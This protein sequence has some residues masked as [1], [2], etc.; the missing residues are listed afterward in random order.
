MKIRKLLQSA[1]AHPLAR[2]V[3][4]DSPETTIVR[5][6]IIQS[7]PFLQRVYREWYARLAG[8]LPRPQGRPV[9]ELGTG[10]GFLKEH[11]PGLLTSDILHLPGLDLVLEGQALPFASGVLGGIVMVNVFH[12][13]PR[14]QSFLKE[15]ARCVAPGGSLAMIEPWVSDWSRWV[16]SRLHYE[17]FDPQAI[18]W[19]FPVSGPLSGANGALPWMIFER[20]R[21]LFE[22][23]FPEW[24]VKAIR[25]CMPLSYLLSGGVSMRSLAPGWSY[26]IAHGFERL[27][28]P[29]MGELAMFAHIVLVRR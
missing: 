8:G 29:W 22:V 27:L 13:I 9:L 10:A 4:I 5:R 23:A 6:K 28:Q 14:P 17:P 24:Q 25:P 11:L 12:H 2:G 20:D 1:L 19:D 7:K 15:A 16:Y 26:A 21:I 18:E 3:D